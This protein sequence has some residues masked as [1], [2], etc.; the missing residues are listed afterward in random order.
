MAYKRVVAAAVFALGELVVRNGDPQAPAQAVM[1]APGADLQR[2]G[3]I[4]VA[5][6]CMTCR[7]FT[8]DRHADPA[9]P[10]G[11]HGLHRRGLHDAQR[12]DAQ[13]RLHQPLLQRRKRRRGRRVAGHDEQLDPPCHELLGDLEREPLELLTAAGTV[14]EA[15]RVGEIDEV[16]RR[17]LDEQLAAVGSARER[18]GTTRDWRPCSCPPWRDTAARSVPLAA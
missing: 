18:S 7:F 1:G 13:R 17:E 16:L 2:S 6:T 12:L 3:A 10:R 4:S 15:R 9:A 5:R 14:R 11:R 8:P